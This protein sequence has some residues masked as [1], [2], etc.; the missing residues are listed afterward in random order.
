MLALDPARRMPADDALRS[1]YLA[2]CDS[3]AAEVV[4]DECAIYDDKEARRL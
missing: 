2:G 1:A 4:A 3:T